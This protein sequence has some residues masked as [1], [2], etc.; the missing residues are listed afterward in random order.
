MS[1]NI[2]TRRQFLQAAVAGSALS[3]G[4]FGA[5]AADSSEEN[6]PVPATADACVFIWLPG[7][8][9]QA[10]TWDPKEHTPFRVGMKGSE[11]LATFPRIPTSA[12]GIFI[13]AGLE[14]IASVMN[15]GTI[16]RSVVAPTKFG[17]IHLKAQYAMMTGYIFPAGV[18]APSLGS[19]V[20]NLRDRRAPFVPAYF[21]IGRNISSA[22]DND[23]FVATY[24]GSGF[25][26]PQYAPFLV[27][28]PQEGLPTLKAVAGMDRGRLDRRQLLLQRL[29]GLADPAIVHSKQATAY[30]QAM[31]DARA[32][33]DSPVKQAFQLHEEKPTTL[34]AYGT[35]RFGQGCLLAR[36]LIEVGARFVEVEYP[37]KAFVFFD[38]HEHGHTRMH[39]LKKEIDGPIAQL[40]LD[41][42][43]RGLLKRTLVVIATEFGR[44]VALNPK[45]EGTEEFGFAEKQ[46]GNRLIIA[47]KAM[48]GHHGHFSSASCMVFFG[49]GIKQGLVYG[50]TAERHPMIPVEQPAP[51]IDLHATIYAALGI[52]PAAYRLT[53]ERPFYVTKDGKG[54]PIEELFA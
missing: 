4:T 44:T 3:L 36:R 34:A 33:M 53:E 37:Y 24:Q 18:A 38:T 32:M 52:S 16:V 20:A 30:G 35:S 48:Y 23:R 31:A 1:Q 39:K 7:G 13:S 49:G 29:Q 43:D 21:D 19:W 51:L 8:V 41:L 6:P 54:T 50:K 17:A 22:D 10:D 14:R 42:E 11:V 25:L 40:V 15:R 28:N 46:T 26:G 12:Q 5:R 45:V 47:N 2:W 9:S 27:P